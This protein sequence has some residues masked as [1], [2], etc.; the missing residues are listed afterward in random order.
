MVKLNVILVRDLRKMKG[1]DF[2]SISELTIGLRVKAYWHPENRYY[3][4]ILREISGDSFFFLFF[5]FFTFPFFLFFCLPCLD[6]IASSMR[7]KLFRNYFLFDLFLSKILQKMTLS[8]QT[9]K[10][11]ELGKKRQKID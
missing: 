1:G 2:S 10:R 7:K 9:I 6:F 11:K 4:A 8:S 5:F 3:E